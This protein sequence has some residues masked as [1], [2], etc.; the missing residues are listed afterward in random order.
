MLGFLLSRKG[1]NMRMLET[2]FELSCKG[3]SWPKIVLVGRGDRPPEGIPYLRWDDSSDKLLVFRLMLPM[4]EKKFTFFKWREVFADLTGEEYEPVKLSY[5]P[6]AEDVGNNS[7]D[8][9]TEGICDKTLKELAMDT[10]SSVDMDL[11]L[12]MKLVPKFF[13]ELAD[14]IKVNLT[15]SYQWTDG[16]NKKLGICCGYLEERPRKRSLVI[17]DISASIPD[18]LSA[19]MMTL[20][21][22]ITDITSADLILTGGISKFYTNEE[23][24]K[25]D[26]DEERRSIPR[27]NE[28]SVFKSILKTHNMDYD[29]VI[30]FGDSDNP[31]PIK[32]DKKINTK[33]LYDFFIGECD[34]YGTNYINGTGY[35]R[36]V[37]ENKPSVQIHRCYD[38]ARLFRG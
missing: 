33:H 13:G 5:N 23:V 17:L 21:K 24:L 22:T 32:L 12:K 14:V 4:L 10:G 31:G 30:S 18:G 29:V 35:A 37:T 6:P 15:N 28:S 19:G 1:K 20:I 9:S 8:E 2:P 26:I 38:W 34:I 16:Y 27:S 7:Y 25:M 11:L 36:W 3:V